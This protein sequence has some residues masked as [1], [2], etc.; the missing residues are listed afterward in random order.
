MG[1]FFFFF[2]RKNKTYLE[3]LKIGIC[4]YS[5]HRALYND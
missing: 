2:L 3:F 5:F 4:D 1:I